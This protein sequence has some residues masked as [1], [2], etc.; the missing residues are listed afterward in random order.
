MTKNP[1]SYKKIGAL[2]F[3]AVISSSWLSAEEYT[4]ELGTFEQTI[5]TDSVAMPAKHVALKLSP[6][7]WKSYE[8]K[9]VVAHG[10]VVKKGDFLVSIDSGG[11]DKK[12]E[13]LTAAIAKETILLEK[14]ELELAEFKVTTKEKLAEAEL[15]YTRFNESLKFYKEVTKPGKISDLDY[16]VT[17]AQNYLAYSQEELDQLNKNV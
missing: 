15:K 1:I 8:I 11:L 10:L 13:E 3:G 4:V 12:I 5:K 7:V 9:N 16:A 6:Q 2:F 14:A 17:R